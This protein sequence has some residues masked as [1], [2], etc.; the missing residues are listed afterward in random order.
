MIGTQSGLTPVSTPRSPRIAR[1][2][3]LVPGLGQAYYGAPRR[4]LQYLL[5]VVV[6]GGVLLLLFL[7]SV[8]ASA[9]PSLAG[10]FNGPVVVAVSG[11]PV[12]LRLALLFLA[13]IVE[14]TLLVVAISFWIA[15]SWDARQGALARNAGR[16][17]QPT[18]WYVRLKQFLFD[19][20]DEE[21]AN[22]R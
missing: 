7:P 17:H 20:P 3:S 22:G 13:E 19:D 18:W 2:L 11:L 16:E 21:K 4:G 6:P 8:P 14:L 5:G 15:A 10:A 1:A 9:D 12:V